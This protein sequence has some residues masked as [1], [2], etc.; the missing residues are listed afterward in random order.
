MRI[1]EKGLD[2]DEIFKQM[3]VFRE[4]DLDWRSGRVMGYIYDAGKEAEEI[5][6]K[7]YMMYLTEN[8]LDPT[9]FPSLARFENEL[10]SMVADHVGGD[11]DVVGNFTSGGTESILMAVK[12]ARDYFRVH[13]PEIVMPEMILPTTAHAAF[14][15]ASVYFDVSVVPVSVNSETYKA[16]VEAV[17]RAITENTILL[18]GSAPSYAHGVID[19]IYEMGQI[20]LEHDILF[21]TD[22]CVGGLML[23]YLKQLGEPVPDFGFDIPG[24]TSVSVDLHKYGYTP[25]NASLILYRN[26]SIRKHQIFACA[27]WPG[28]TVVNSAFQSSKTGGSLAASWAVMNFIGHNGYLE[29]ARKTL[30]ATHKLVQGIAEIEDLRVM[31]KPEMVMFAVTSDT[32]NV[33]HIIDEMKERGWYIQPQL[34]FQNSQKNFHI[35]VNVSSVDLVDD[36]LNALRDSVEAARSLKTGELVTTI[37]D[38]LANMGPN[39]INDDNISDMMAMAGL[40][41]GDL[42]ERMADINEIMNTLTVNQRELMLKAFLNDL[43]SQKKP[44]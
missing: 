21:H 6:K 39:D 35:S 44:G 19:P 38:A 5:G 32:V 37:K 23:P 14:H 15:K 26:K 24:V 22:A 20:A 3:T 16:D 34:E 17:K 36:L 1:P 43:F 9:A 18:V 11:K 2:K 31:V 8:G 41:G 7:A 29:I 25:K 42:P 12:T 4:E 28:Y 40:D 27:G 10:V 13:R 33:F 30:E